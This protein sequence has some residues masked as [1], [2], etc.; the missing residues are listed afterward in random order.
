MARL[1]IR[2]SA[3]N[4]R[5]SADVQSSPAFSVMSIVPGAKRS[6]D[7]TAHVP[8]VSVVDAVWT[9]DRQT[10]EQTADAWTKVGW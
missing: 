4:R 2:D 1:A 5:R 8:D 10:D 3:H 6:A 9:V 7:P